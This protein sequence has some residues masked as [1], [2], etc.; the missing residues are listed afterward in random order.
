MATRSLIGIVNKDG[1]IE[2]IYNHWDGYPTYVGTILTLFYREAETRKLL[3][4]GNRSSLHAKPT[5][6]DTYAE[7]GERDQG[8]IKHKSWSEFDAFPKSGAEYVYLY[9]APFYTGNG[10]WDWVGFKVNLDD[11]L[12][13]LGVLEREV[14]F[15]ETVHYPVA[16]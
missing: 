8:S 7:R 14:K 6:V 12:T 3:K 15:K 13:P 4:L 9:S 10:G 5:K 11:T 16:L 2:T 1:S